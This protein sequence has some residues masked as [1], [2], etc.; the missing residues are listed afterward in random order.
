M[1]DFNELKKLILDADSNGTLIISKH[2][3]DKVSTITT[4][5]RTVVSK[6]VAD[7]LV[8]FINEEEYSVEEYQNVEYP[9]S[10]LYFA[11]TPNPS[12]QYTIASSGVTG[13]YPTSS[14]DTLIIV[15]GGSAGIHMYGNSSSDIQSRVTNSTLINKRKLK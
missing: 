12:S 8:Q 6:N 9:L 4:A 3:P 11:I 14:L 10:P 7:N 5:F 1:I 2:D 15:S 13:N